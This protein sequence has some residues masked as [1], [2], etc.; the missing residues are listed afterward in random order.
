MEYSPLL[1]A[2]SAAFLIPLYVL[3]AIGLWH[4]RSCLRPVLLFFATMWIAHI[5][6]EV[7]MRFRVP[8]TDP[9]LIVFASFALV[10]LH[11]LF[12]ESRADRRLRLVRATADVRR[13]DEA[14]IVR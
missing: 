10:E 9:L 3:A 6:F 4:R 13:E 14:G 11:D 5:P 1:V 2:G 7:V 12:V 8:F